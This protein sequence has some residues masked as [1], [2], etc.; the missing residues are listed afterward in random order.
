MEIFH[1]RDKNAWDDDDNIQELSFLFVCF[2][3][4]SSLICF[5]LKNSVSRNLI[6]IFCRCNNYFH[7]IRKCV[8]VSCKNYLSTQES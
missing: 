7:F 5:G 3:N 8:L 1:L 6:Y 4:L 2:A